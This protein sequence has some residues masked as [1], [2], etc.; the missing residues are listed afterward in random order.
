MKTYRGSCHRGRIQFYAE[1]GSLLWFIARAGAGRA[2]AKV[3][4][5]AVTPQDYAAFI[6][7]E[8]AI[9]FKE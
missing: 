9:G 1:G 7:Q 6:A 3:S 4:G 8:Q 2:L 5:I